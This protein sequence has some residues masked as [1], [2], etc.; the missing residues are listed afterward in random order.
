MHDIPV[1]I[2]KDNIGR[3]K[4]LG[5]NIPVQKD[6]VLTFITNEGAKIKLTLPE[7]EKSNLSTQ[8]DLDKAERSVRPSNSAKSVEPQKG[9]NSRPVLEREPLSVNQDDTV[10]KK[11][12]RSR[13]AQE[14]STMLG[15]PVYEQNTWKE[16]ET[17]HFTLQTNN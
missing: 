9:H 10:L 1:L 15:S 6:P 16:N 12:A 13:D 14:P 4:R 7:G 8:N 3:N 17:K 2:G 5:L 11:G